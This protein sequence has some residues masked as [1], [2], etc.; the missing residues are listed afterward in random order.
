ME[1]KIKKER[2]IEILKDA[3][4]K[5][6]GSVLITATTKDEIQKEIDF[7]DLADEIL[8]KISEYFERND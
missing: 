6:W 3:D 2:I 7:S 8:S 5:F 1:K 4:G